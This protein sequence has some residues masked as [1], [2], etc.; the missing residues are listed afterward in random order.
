MEFIINYWYLIITALAILVMA[1]LF[2][3]DFAKKSPK[4]KLESVKQWAIYACALAQAHLGSGTGQLKMRET[5]NMFL[6]TFPTLAQVISFDTYKN[7]AEMALTELKEMLKTNPNIQNAIIKEGEQK[8][9][10]QTSQ[11]E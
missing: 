6:Q 11:T 8:Y 2:I 4:E 10:N 7:T 5:Y 3:V 9:E 1:I